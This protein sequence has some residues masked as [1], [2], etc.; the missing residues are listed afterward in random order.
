MS[1]R[2]GVRDTAAPRAAPRVTTIAGGTAMAILS[3]APV[4]I[5]RA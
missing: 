5:A 2:R 1:G 3:A 4:C